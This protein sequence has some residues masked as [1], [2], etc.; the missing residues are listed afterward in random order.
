MIAKTPTANYVNQ[1]VRGAHDVQLVNETARLMRDAHTA[2]Y[3]RTVLELDAVSLN[4]N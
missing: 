4:V 1:D 3:A 2:S